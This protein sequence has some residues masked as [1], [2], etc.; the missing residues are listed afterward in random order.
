MI[1]DLTFDEWDTAQTSN[2]L[3]LR[4]Q[5]MTLAQDS[6][7]ARLQPN[8]IPVHEHEG[9]YTDNNLNPVQH[10]SQITPNPP[11]PYRSPPR[12]IPQPINNRSNFFHSRSNNS[13]SSLPE[14]SHPPVNNSRTSQPNISQFFRS[15][16]PANPFPSNTT[17]HPIQTP[18]PPSQPTSPMN[19]NLTNFQ[20]D[21]LDLSIDSSYQTRIDK[22]E[23]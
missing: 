9:L 20:D 7:D 4:V 6:N 22:G 17:N 1:I 14:A 23:D 5:G 12:S 3:R 2:A 21:Q 19:N 18:V 11:I 16:P 13:H 15:L 10:Q 8:A